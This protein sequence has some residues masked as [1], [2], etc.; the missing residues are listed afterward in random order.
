[1]FTFDKHC[2]SWRILY[3]TKIYHSRDAYSSSQFENKT[4]IETIFR[5]IEK[6]SSE[7]FRDERIKLRA[8]YSLDAQ[9]RITQPTALP[10]VFEHNIV[11][12]INTR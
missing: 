4:D 1:M 7:S 9:H 5:T 3:C 2:S 12:I 10:L 8:R 11:N 6:I